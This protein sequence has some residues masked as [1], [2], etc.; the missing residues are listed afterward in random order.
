MTKSVPRFSTKKAP[1]GAQSH[2]E[3]SVLESCAG[4]GRVAVFEAAVLVSQDFPMPHSVWQRIM[5]SLHSALR[6]SKCKYAASGGRREGKQ[7][8]E[9]RP[10]W[11][12]HSGLALITNARRR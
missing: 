8:G 9:S 5:A 4:K 10:P 3:H 6:I 11:S 12:K 2:E 7:P 1:V